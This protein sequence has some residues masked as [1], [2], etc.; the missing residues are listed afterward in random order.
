MATWITPATKTNST[1]TTAFWNAEVRDKVNWLYNLLTTDTNDADAGLRIRRTLGTSDA[2][3]LRRATDAAARLAITADGAMRWTNGTAVWDIGITR[4]GDGELSLNR[5]ATS[6]GGGYL[7]FNQQAAKVTGTAAQS[8]TNNTWVAMNFA[9]LGSI[10]IF[11]PPGATPMWQDS[12]RDRMVAP[13]V[14][15]YAVTAT[16]TATANAS[17][18]RRIIG[19]GINGADP[20]LENMQTYE[21]GA[22]AFDINMVITQVLMLTD[23]DYVRLMV[24][25]NSSGPI[26]HNNATLSMV[27]IGNGA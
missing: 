23:G 18:T 10:V 9:A 19:L 26:S 15:V 21:K 11:Q 4:N 3:Q 24:N 13:S 12:V 25:Q 7:S 14:G 6:T 5:S 17:G 8:I 1:L 16:V 20:N 27:K 2:L 22:E